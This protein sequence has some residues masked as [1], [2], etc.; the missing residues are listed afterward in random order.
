MILTFTHQK[1][2]FVELYVNNEYKGL[3]VFMEKTKEIKIELILVK[4][5]LRI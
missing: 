2:K 5:N 3:Y 1:T 4:I